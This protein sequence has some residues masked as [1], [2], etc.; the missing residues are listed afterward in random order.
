MDKLQADRWR[1]VVERTWRPAALLAR[2]VA[3]VD[4]QVRVRSGDQEVDARSVLGLMSLG[5]RQGDT[6]AIQATGP[7]AAEA[8][9]RVRELAERNFDE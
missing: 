2:S 5:A 3:E 7:Q 9:N 8:V 6:I 1:G 4:A